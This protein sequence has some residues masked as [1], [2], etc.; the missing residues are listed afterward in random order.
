MALEVKTKELPSY[1]NSR[2]EVKERGRGIRSA[3]VELEN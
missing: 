1:E 3:S 2:G